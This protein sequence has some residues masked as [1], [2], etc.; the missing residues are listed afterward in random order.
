MGKASQSLLEEMREIAIHSAFKHVTHI[1]INKSSSNRRRCITCAPASFC[2]PSNGCVRCRRMPLSTPCFAPPC[3]ATPCAVTLHQITRCMNGIVLPMSCV[4]LGYAVLRC[5][6]PV[7][8]KCVVRS[9]I[10]VL[11]C[12]GVVLLCCCGVVSYAVWRCYGECSSFL[13]SSM[14]NH[15]VTEY[16][17][18]DKQQHKKLQQNTEHTHIINTYIHKNDPH[19]YI[20][21][22]IYTYITKSTPSRTRPLCRCTAHQGRGRSGMTDAC[23]RPN[24]VTWSWSWYCYVCRWTCKRLLSLMC[25]CLPG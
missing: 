15:T 12:G 11:C 17:I 4:V 13:S 22:Y 21:I 23:T 14:F 19:I 5:T 2:L 8:C 20:Y 3:N 9:I 1:C 6:C 7:L 18:Q 16:V 24:K 25:C 10:V